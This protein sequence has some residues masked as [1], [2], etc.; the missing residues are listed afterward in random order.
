[1][2]SDVVFNAGVI[3]LKRAAALVNPYSVSIQ[4]KQMDEVDE[5]KGNK[6]AALLL[7]Y[8]LL[9]MVEYQYVL[10]SYLFRYFKFYFCV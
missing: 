5:V 2:P 4:E 8:S 6:I 9:C 1:M 7:Y 3:L 10:F